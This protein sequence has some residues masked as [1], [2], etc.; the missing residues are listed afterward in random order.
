M[1]VFQ[2]HRRHQCIEVRCQI[3]LIVNTYD[4]CYFIIASTRAIVGGIMLALTEK[5][6]IALAGHTRDDFFTGWIAIEDVCLCPWLSVAKTQLFTNNLK[7]MQSSQEMDLLLLPT[8]HEPSQS[9]SECFFLALIQTYCTVGPNR[10]FFPI[11]SHCVVS[12]YNT[13]ASSIEWDDVVQ[14]VRKYEMN[15]YYVCK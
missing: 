10:A 12:R 1:L 9:S 8:H 13:D 11:W 2:I 4:N 15:V 7:V 14:K 3:S 5:V 6:F